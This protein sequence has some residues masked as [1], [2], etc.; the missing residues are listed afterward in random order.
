[1]NSGI[2]IITTPTINDKFY[3]GSAKSISSRWQFHLSQFK[4]NIHPNIHLQNTVN[5]YGLDIL[6][7]K[8]LFYCEIKDLIFFEQRA[9]DIYSPKYNICKIAGSC[10]G[11]KHSEETKIKISNSHKGIPG[12]PHTEDTKERISAKKL[13]VLKSDE[14]KAKMSNAQRGK[15]ISEETRKKISEL[16]KGNKNMLGKTHSDET[17]KKWSEDRKG[18]P[19]PNK[20]KTFS[21]EVRKR[22]SEAQMGKTIPQETRDKIQAALKG[23]PRS[24]E[25]KKKISETKQR[26]KLKDG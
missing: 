14:T 22:M 3:I 20:G 18:S 15:V 8:V 21:E 17:K 7:F 11:R 2:Y 10:L 1:M 5:K 25:V 4:R 6:E 12:K 9:I 23:K 19:G 13:G 26:N 24:E 16:K